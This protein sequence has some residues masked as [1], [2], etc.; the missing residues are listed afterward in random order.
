MLDEMGLEPALRWYVDG[1]RKRSHIDVT[2]HLENDL[3]RLPTNC[4]T[5]IFR[6]VQAAL[7]NIQL[8]SGSQTALIRLRKSVEGVML[9]IKDE[10]RGIPP[11]KLS[12]VV[13]G[14]GAHGLGLRG[15]RERVE[16]LGGR[17]EIASSNRGTEI[18][19]AIPVAAS[20][21]AAV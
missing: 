15:M 8:H 9:T 17:F 6:I 12:Q 2:F 19:V 16:D 18:A 13:E 20:R 4:E 10:G 14:T 21:A 3:G 1:L 5:A 11:E 7:T